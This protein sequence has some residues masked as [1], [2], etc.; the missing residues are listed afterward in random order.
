MTP[1]ELSAEAVIQRLSLIPHPEG[2]HY[3]ETFRDQETVD[4]GNG[5][6]QRAAGTAIYYLLE[7]GQIS[8]WH[9]VDA[10]EVW[11]WYAGAPLRLSMSDGTDEPVR[12]IVIGNRLEDGEYPQAA[13]PKGIWQRAESL[14]AWSLVGCTV[15]PGFKFEGFVLAPEGFR[16]GD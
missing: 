12:D 11:H 15:S 16:G 9:K 6:R 4:D 14:G 7:R 13:I 5:D 8:R 1:P 10:S 2:G 3:R